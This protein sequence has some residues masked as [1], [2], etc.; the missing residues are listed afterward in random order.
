MKIGIVG[1]GAVGKA[2]ALGFKSGGHDIY[3]NDLRQPE[4]QKI[5]EKKDL[6]D[7]CNLVFVCVPTPPKIGGSLDL[8]CVEQAIEELNSAR[9]LDSDNPIIVIRSTVAPGTTR[10]LAARFPAMKFAYNPEFLRMEHACDD[11]LHPDRIVIGAHSTD[12]AN[13]VARAYEG[14]SCP[15]IITDLDTAETVKLVSN[16]F[17]V[18]RVA[19]ACEVANF[20]KVLGVNAKKVMEAVCLDSRIGTS[21]LD[22]SKGPIPPNSHCLPKDMFGLIQYLEAKGYSSKLLKTAYDVGIKKE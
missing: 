4:N 12:I 14:W 10:G 1:N 7:N 16:C 17:L 6:M 15:I 18:Y 2:T 22:P 20:C 13:E 19:Y 11:F 3:I 21:H 5:Y 9:K 8:S